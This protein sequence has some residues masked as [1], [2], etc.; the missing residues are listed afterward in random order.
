MSLWVS[1]LHVSSF[2]T[3]LCI[4]YINIEHYKE[5]APLYDDFQHFHYENLAKL[6]VRELELK[7]QDGLVDIGAGTGAITHL[8]WKIAGR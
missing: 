1:P 3:F 2:F 7:P 8:C 5:L 6:A 4:Y